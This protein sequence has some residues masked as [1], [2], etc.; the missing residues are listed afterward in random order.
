[1]SKE[2]GISQ[3]DSNDEWERHFPMFRPRELP[4]IFRTNLQSDNYKVLQ[5]GHLVKA[6]LETQ[7]LPRFSKRKRNIKLETTGN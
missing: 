2:F 3:Q 5:N 7:R 6:S 1:M 4:M